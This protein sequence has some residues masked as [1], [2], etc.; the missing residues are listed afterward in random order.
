MPGVANSPPASVRC[1]ANSHAEVD[2][3]LGRLPGLAVRAVRVE[4]RVIPTAAAVDWPFCAFDRPPPPPAVAGNVV[5]AERA[6]P[7]R[8]R[9]D[10]V[11]TERER[12]AARVK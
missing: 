4:V 9:A 5:D 6:A 10:L 11:G 1:S 3:A 7:R 2:M 8:V 12:A